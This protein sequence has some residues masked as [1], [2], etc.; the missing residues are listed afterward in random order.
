MFARL[1]LEV[2]EDR[3]TPAPDPA[4]GLVGKK[5]GIRR[6]VPLRPAMKGAEDG[7][8]SRDGRAALKR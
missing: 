3:V 7:R 2:L 1:R 4:G 6:P 8:S 5:V